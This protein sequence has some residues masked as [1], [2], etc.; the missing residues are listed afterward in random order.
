MNDV[1]LTAIHWSGDTSS[2]NAQM[3]SSF[4]EGFQEHDDLQSTPVVFVNHI[5][6]YEELYNLS[7]I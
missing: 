5:H 6:F 3:T 1:V 7:S 2:Q 4:F